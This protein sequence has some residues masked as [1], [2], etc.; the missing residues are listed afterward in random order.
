MG[1]KRLS[2]TSHVAR[3]LLQSAAL[4]KSDRTVVWEYVSNG[5]QYCEAGTAPRVEVVLRPEK[6]IIQVSDNGRGMD[7]NGLHNF[8][9]MHGENIDRKSG[10]PGRGRFGTGKAAAFGIA[11]HLAVVSV[12]N[13]RRS[14]VELDRKDLEKASSGPIPVHVLEMEVP[15]DAAN[16]TIIEISQIRLRKLDQPAI[17]QFIEQ[18]LARWPGNPVVTVNGVEC[19]YAEPAT[20]QICV[21][22]A[23]ERGVTELGGA[24]L[25]IKVARAPLPKQ[26]QGVSVYANGSWIGLTS[27]GIEGQ[28]MADLLFG[29]ID[30]PGLD[31][32]RNGQSA[33]DMSRSLELNPNHELVPI[34]W[35]FVGRELDQVRRELVKLEKE[36]R[37]DEEL[38]KL[39][40]EADLI[41]QVINEDFQ[42]FRGRVQTTKSKGGK[43][44]D[45]TSSLASDDQSS[46]VNSLDVGGEIPAGIVSED[47][48]PGRG[49]GDGGEGGAVPERRPIAEADPEGQ[50]LGAEA[51]P[52]TQRPTRRGGFV[53]DF[54]NLGEDDDRARYADSERAILINLDHPQIRAARGIEGIEAPTFRR[55]AYEVAFSEYAVALASEMANND[56]YIDPSD[57]IFDIRQTI[58]RMARRAAAL[59]EA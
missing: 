46:E 30:V 36:R 57:P 58:N 9:V 33:F 52:R 12:Q 29:E 18:N 40:R 2:V 43:G 54:R 34:L 8:F 37:N 53:V 20:A 38:K 13:G 26:R 22:R 51:P 10:R 39:A 41:S 50:P 15:T 31:E 5:L 44:R 47:G 48:A 56:Q 59:Y 17:R 42:E 23:Y 21:V 24:C 28:P 6:R 55:L 27:A 7:R 32:D 14:R 11:N 45:P 4:F 1:E 16:G 3:D 49:D 35:A 19:E 25:T